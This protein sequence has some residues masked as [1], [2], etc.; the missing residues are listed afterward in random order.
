MRYRLGSKNVCNP[1][2]TYDVG[3]FCKT[4]NKAYTRCRDSKSLDIYTHAV[5]KRVKLIFI[6]ETPLKSI[7][8]GIIVQY[9]ET[10][11]NT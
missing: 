11:I 1:K 2:R 4:E 5:E 8:G 7:G 3:S 9:N 10:Y 6:G